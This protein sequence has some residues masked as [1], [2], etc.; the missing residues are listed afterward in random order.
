MNGNDVNGGGLSR[1]ECAGL[2]KGDRIH[3]G[4]RTKSPGHFS[5][6]RLSTV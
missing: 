5:M 1:R 2:I 6:G 4:H 3:F